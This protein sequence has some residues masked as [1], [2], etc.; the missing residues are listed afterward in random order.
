M[1][2]LRHKT[3]LLLLLFPLLTLRAQEQDS[4]ANLT[5]DQAVL[6]ARVRRPM[7]E[8]IEGVSG[9]VSVSQIRS[10]PAILG[11]PDPLRFARLLPSVQVN[12]ETDGGLYMQGSEFSHTILS[13]GG[14]PVY[15]ASH[16]LGLFSIFNATH[17]TA[18]DYR[19]SAGQ[20]P[21]LGGRIDMIPC[22]TLHRRFGGSVSAGLISGQ[23]TLRIPCGDKSSLTVSLRRS[24]I[25]LL[26]GSFL[27]FAGSPIR[28]GFT[29]GNL[30]WLWKPTP[31]DRVW[32]DLFGGRDKASF[33]Y[34]QAGI[35]MSA[36]WYNALGAVHWNH[37]WDETTLRQTAYA[38]L[39]GLDAH[40]DVNY[41]VGDLPSHIRTYGYKADVLWR[42]WRF[43]ADAAFH[44]VQ[45]QNPRS[46]G[47]YN[48]TNTSREPVQTGLEAT[49]SATWDRVLTS[50]FQLKASLGV[51]LF[52]S[53]ERRLYWGPTP[54]V[55]AIFLLDRGGRI[56]L[57]YGIH[58]QNLFQTGFTNVGMPSEFYLL[59][60]ALS[61]PQWSQNAALSYNLDFARKA[62][63]LSAEIYYKR[64]YNQIEYKG[65]LMEILNSQYSVASSVLRGHGHAFG[66]NLML[67]K[68]TGRLT[69]WIGYA[70]SRSL[71]QFDDPQFPDIY[72]SD[73][74]RLHEL[75]VVATYDIGRFDFGGT[76]VVASGTPYTRPESFY[77]IGDRL[78]CQYGERNAARLPAYIR[79]D[80]SVN[81]YIHKDARWSNGLNLSIY[82]VLCR[83]NAVGFGVHTN[84]AGTA[85]TFR[86]TSFGIKFMPSLSYFHRF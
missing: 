54:Q 70:L 19:T 15:G 57:R 65:T 86:P 21:R 77:V 45:P 82:N 40:L 69:G 63:S 26:Y 51:N 20:L 42:D 17:Y 1:R 67:Q 38:T 62:F 66:L 39:N 41:A 30:T 11:N 10:V 68:Q 5:L 72:P 4:V 80:V 24:W 55:D 34:E 6:T 12:S 7:L 2:G 28:Y 58:R 60:G 22:D 83:E 85:Y 27:R 52:L 53:P 29:D 48:M 56:D 8:N 74:E 18:M 61:D 35:N 71:R 14:V 32:V 76:F 23:G 46:E 59:A 44:H 81:W 47:Y 78:I 84:K 49:F 3:A 43:A 13:I 36:A 37:Y 31:R 50:F 33:D 64:L 75:N 73:H 16:M 79:M 25:N 9:S